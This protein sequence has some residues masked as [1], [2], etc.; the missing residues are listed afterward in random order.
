MSRDRGFKITFQ[1]I[2]CDRCKA[3][4]IRG[5]PCPDCGRRP[6]EWEI[7]QDLQ[8]RRREL[9]AARNDLS[10]GDETETPDTSSLV[11]ETVLDEILELV[12]R[13]V[14]ALRRAAEPRGDATDVRQLVQDLVAIRRLLTRS[15]ERRPYVEIARAAATV[16]RELEQAIL[17]YLDAMT[18][19][20]PLQAQTHADQA[21]QHL[22]RSAAAMNETR[23]GL[24]AARSIDMSSVAAMAMSLLEL[25][26]KQSGKD[27]IGMVAAA[28]VR[29]VELL[30][31]S[32]PEAGLQLALC[33]GVTA[34]EFDR[35]RLTQTVVAAYA[36]FKA[37]GPELARLAAAEPQLVEDFVDVQVAAFN[38][39]WNAM[40]AVQNAQTVRQAI[41]ALLDVNTGLLEAPGAFFARTLLLITGQKQSSYAKLKTGYAT[42]HLRSLQAARPEL[43]MLLVGIDDHLRTAKSHYQVTYTDE[44]IIT[45]ARGETRTTTLVDL[46]DLVLTGVESV[47]ACVVALTQAFAELNIR[48]DPVELTHALGVEPVDLAEMSVRILAQTDASVYVTSNEL[49]VELTNT[50]QNIH[51]TSVVAALGP[52]LNEAPRFRIVDHETNRTLIG[53][54]LPFLD[55]PQGQFA[56][57][58]RVIKVSLDSKL[59]EHPCMNRDQFRVWASNWILQFLT[60]GDVESMR[61]LRELS[62]LAQET[63]DAELEAVIRRCRRWVHR[64]EGDPELLEILRRWRFEGP[65]WEAV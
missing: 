6:A 19:A 17:H 62:W 31:V 11:D 37:A 52:I 13:L 28:D 47:T 50:P 7:D 23:D 35:A 56:E 61:Q 64:Q 48:F 53:P 59:N 14:P 65:D 34:L 58:L 4:R 18:A 22:D 42:E 8:H 40:H 25:Q 2:D 60:T 3:T 38:S 39:S 1:V 36:A 16:V 24:E 46:H 33:E 9:T 63:G 26:L 49:I 57:Q 10:A 27:A 41:E 43:A 45:V 12:P 5:V 32:K 21:Q 51:L 29:L 54:T 30:G 55:N 20:V 44:A 15:K